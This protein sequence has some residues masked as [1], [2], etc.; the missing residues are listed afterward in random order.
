MS[1]RVL[2]AAGLGPLYVEVVFVDD[3]EIR[4]LNQRFRGIDAATDVLSF[5]AQ[6]GE[7][8][9]GTELE[10]G[11]LVIS[12]PT[13]KTQARQ[14]GHSDDEEIAVLTAHGLM[15]LLGFDHERD[16]ASAREMAEL[17]MSLLAAADVAVEIA[18]IGRAPHT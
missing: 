1:A 9:P 10:L 4:S 11:S 17:E 15:H 5:P 7:P 3:Q 14:L 2:A 13:A 8:M 12:L 6:E 16:E 18:L